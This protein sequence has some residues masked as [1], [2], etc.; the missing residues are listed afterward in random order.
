MSKYKD[1]LIGCEE[2]GEEVFQDDEWSGEYPE[3]TENDCYGDNA[4]EWEF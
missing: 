1:Y 4:Q 3:D 2:N